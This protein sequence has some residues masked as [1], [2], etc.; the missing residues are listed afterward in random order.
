MAS[1]S[2][3]ST[4]QCRGSA[5]NAE[6]RRPNAERMR[7]GECPGTS[8][9]AFEIRHSACGVPF[10]IQHSAF[11]IGRLLLLATLFIA[12]SCGARSYAPGAAPVAAQALGAQP[13]ENLNAVLWV[14]S[15]LEYEAAALQAYRLASLQL[16]RALKRPSWTAA[17]EQTGN[18][19]GLPPAV[20]V[21]VDETVL[22][23]SY[24]QARMIRDGTRFSEVTWNAWVEEQRATAIPG[25]VEFTQQAAARGVTVFYVTNRTHAEERA[26]RANLAALGFPLAATV[27]AVLTRGEQPEWKTSAKG[28]RRAQVAQQFRILLLVGDDLGDFV[29]DVSGAPEQRRVRA[30]AYRDRWGVQWIM[31]AN[32][33]YGSWERA[34]VG[35]S[36]DSIAAKRAAL[37]FNSLDRS[38]SN[39]V[40]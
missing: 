32:P 27:D 29:N 2:S 34:V 12:A 16:D 4:V 9:S 10:G 20:I 6:C 17:L 38:R 28:T 23:N 22:D 35:A 19:D 24:Y 25:A 7:N 30:E 13:D 1:S 33:T 36:P 5:S 37:R 18:V 8:T 14:Q 40:N 26:T 3:L 21:D 31:L 39:D 11:G 15:A